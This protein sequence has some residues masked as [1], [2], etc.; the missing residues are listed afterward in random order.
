MQTFMEELDERGEAYIDEAERHL[1][2]L[3]DLAELLYRDSIHDGEYELAAE[4]LTSLKAVL[5]VELLLLEHTPAF[6]N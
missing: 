2:Q 1:A 6:R 4:A 3:R 5:Q